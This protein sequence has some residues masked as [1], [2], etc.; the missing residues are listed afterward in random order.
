MQFSSWIPLKGGDVK[1]EE[2]EEDLEEVGSATGEKKVEEVD[3]DIEGIDVDV[4]SEEE[5]AEK[6]DKTD[7]TW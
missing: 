2:G 5:E 7:D 6:A 1:V 3:V 4:G